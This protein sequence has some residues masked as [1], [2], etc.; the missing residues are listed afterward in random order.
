MRNAILSVVSARQL[1]QAVILMDSAEKFLPGWE[2]LVYVLD[3]Q[4]NELITLKKSEQIHAFLHSA[5]ELFLDTFYEYAF[6]YEEIAFR[7][8][9]KVRAI[10]NLLAEY[11]TVLL[12]DCH[13]VF[14]HVPSIIGEKYCRSNSITD[15]V[16][17]DAISDEDVPESF[18][19]SDKTDSLLFQITRGV[20]TKIFLDWCIQ[21]FDYMM[22]NYCVT[23]IGKAQEIKLDDQ[24]EFIQ[25]WKKYGQLY[26]L[27]YITLPIPYGV[28]P[29]KDIQPTQL[30]ALTFVAFPAQEKAKKKDA[31]ILSP[32][33]SDLIQK[34]DGQV[35]ALRKSLSLP[36]KY[37]FDYFSDGVPIF[38][39]LRSYFIE[40]YRLRDNC[41]RDPFHCR[42]LFTDISIVPGD[43]NPL[44]LNAV[45]ECIWKARPDLRRS[46]PDY[47]YAS[48]VAY[49]SWFLSYGVKEY[50]LP[51][52]DIRFIQEH[53]NRVSQS[54][55]SNHSFFA[56][57]V[58]YAKRHVSSR[59]AGQNTTAI[60]VAKKSF[61][62][63]GVNLGGFIRG[64]FGLGEATRIL[65]RTLDAGQIPFTI[66]NFVV[67]KIQKYHNREW[68]SKITN[69]FP[70]NTNLVLS[71]IT[72]GP[73]GYLDSI[74]TDAFKNRYNIGFFYWEL[75]E[76]SDSL[77]ENLLYFDEV[78]AASEFN[79]NS[80]RKV[81][82][83][84]VFVLPC[85]ISAEPDPK[86]DRTY[87]GLPQDTFLFLMMY[88]SRS[89]NQRK[90]PIAAVKAFY[91]AFGDRR[92]VNLVIKVNMPDGLS[93]EDEVFEMVSKHPNMCV[94]NATL[95]KVEVN[96]LIHCCDAFVSLHRSEG[97][98]LG[99]AEAMYQGK[100][101]ILTNWSGNLEYMTKDNCCPV[102]Y[103][104]VE[105]M[106]S[107]GPYLKGSHWAEPSVEHA[108]SY[109][110]KLV[111]DREYYSRI[112][113]NAEKHIRQQFSAEAIGARARKHLKELHLL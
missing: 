41:K 68:E 113:Q 11:D 55:T 28:F 88:D 105:L 102:D 85:C 57:A 20:G 39:L 12:A 81:V 111:E 46:F 89:S 2:R 25:N 35:E 60:A 19:L 94:I 17:C 44:P 76:M 24:T 33:Q 47:K 96:S 40:N 8:L 69:T 103:R 27:D 82:S 108:A 58:R 93:S 91:Q 51:Q 13:L 75:P 83:R 77:S 63:K 21:K 62:P 92:D 6:F 84:P 72:G 54:V 100:P 110:K 50:K 38:F 104:L 90:N 14:Q 22:R 31:P 101:A 48:R 53:F 4:P 37:R 59:A 29:G 112:S 109:M 45:A 95:E 49:I 61:H 106:E 36:L 32:I 70:Y 79:A 5:E 87:F 7:E 3:S 52:D 10:S 99:P 64:D 107:Y 80:F 78:W 9:V 43:E 98:G 73:R 97:F 15:T 16:G 1:P 56:R 34:Y 26:A 18:L 71:N 42:V 30:N 66:D 67:P 23:I 65:A 86:I 74:S